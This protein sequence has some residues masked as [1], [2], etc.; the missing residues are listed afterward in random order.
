MSGAR[1]VLA[2]LALA[3]VSAAAGFLAGSGLRELPSEA[4]TPPSR[5]SEE[6]RD[7][8]TVRAGPVPDDRPRAKAPSAEGPPPAPVPEEPT[9]LRTEHDIERILRSHLKRDPPHERVR[10]VVVLRQALFD[11]QR[12]VPQDWEDEA[13]RRVIGSLQREESRLKDEKP[14]AKASRTDADELLRAMRTLQEPFFWAVSDGPR[15][16]TFFE[17]SADGLRVDVTKPPA[18]LRTDQPLVLLFPEG[19]HEWDGRVADR[20][21]PERD[22]VFQGAGMDTTLLRVR[23]HLSDRDGVAVVLRDLTLFLGAAIEG[24]RG[25]RLRLERCRV[26]GWEDRSG[27][28]LE[29]FEGV[30]YATDC[31][32]EGGYAERGEAAVLDPN[33]RGI[34]GRFERCRFR[35]PLA[36]VEG[37]F[38][39]NVKQIQRSTWIFDSCAFL[40]MERPTPQDLERTRPDGLRFVTCLVDGTASEK[41]LRRSLADLNPEWASVR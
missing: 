10:E 41:G 5:P 9:G 27:A 17:P 14:Q 30:L 37:S 11:A 12:R 7:E 28:L 3:A 18:V 21:A 20:G 23:R 36:I 16:A 24:A 2:G 13:L 35:G 31:R 1:V 29:D 15:F 22:V 26:V 6:P 19:T 8:R 34:L 38:A 33:S 39:G 25:Q 40:E 4:P 32:F